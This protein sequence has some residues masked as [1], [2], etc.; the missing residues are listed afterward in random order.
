MSI[1]GLLPLRLRDQGKCWAQVPSSDFDGGRRCGRNDSREG[2]GA[3]RDSYTEGGPSW[4]S[5]LANL[6]LGVESGHTKIPLS[7]GMTDTGTGF[8]P[9]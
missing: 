1:T 8:T 7:D 5:H 6:V 4:V 3:G 9:V 2:G